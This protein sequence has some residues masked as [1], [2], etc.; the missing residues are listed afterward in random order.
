MFSDLFTVE[1]GQHEGFSIQ[2]YDANVPLF[3]FFC[4]SSLSL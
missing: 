2:T 3:D 1:I 4:D